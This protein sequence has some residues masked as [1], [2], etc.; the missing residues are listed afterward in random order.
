MSPDTIQLHQRNVYTDSMALVA[1]F[2]QSNTKKKSQQMWVLFFSFSQKQPMH[3]NYIQFTTAAN[4]VNQRAWK[5]YVFKKINNWTWRYCK[6]K[7]HLIK[8]LQFQSGNVLA[9]GRQVQYITI[10]LTKSC[11]RNKLGADLMYPFNLKMDLL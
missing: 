8:V 6:Q 2:P 3:V 5:R 7:I 4:K 1:D 9:G 10:A 11:E